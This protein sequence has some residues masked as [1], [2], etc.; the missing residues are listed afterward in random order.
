MSNNSNEKRLSFRRHQDSRQLLPLPI[1]SNHWQ[2]HPIELLL[3]IVFECVLFRRY[4]S[5]LLMI[6]KGFKFPFY[7]K[8]MM[9][10]AFVNNCIIGSFFK[11]PIWLVKIFTRDLGIAILPISEFPT[12]IQ[13]RQLPTIF[14]RHGK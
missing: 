1:G 8:T 2:L 10:I 13:L 14:R 4:C 6:R 7:Q 9:V 5:V 3:M 11:N 12:T